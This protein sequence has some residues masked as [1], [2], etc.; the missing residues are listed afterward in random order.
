MLNDDGLNLNKK[1]VVN[2]KK[3]YKV[4]YIYILSDFGVFSWLIRS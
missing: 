4:E 2:K 1:T 3:S